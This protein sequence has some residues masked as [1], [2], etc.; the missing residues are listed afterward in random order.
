MR[1]RQWIGRLAVV[2]L[3]V[4]FCASPAWAQWQ[5]SSREN[6]WS[7]RF[8]F[9]A[10]GRALWVEAPDGQED[11]PQDLYLR[12]LRFMLGGQITEQLSFFVETDS[13]NLGKAGPD[14]SKSESDLFIQD[15]FV[16][17]A[18]HDAWRVDGGLLLPAMSYHHAQT[19]TGLV[20]T[21]YGPFS[22][23]ESGPLDERVGRDY[24]IQARGYLLGGA[25]ETRFGVYQ[26]RRGIDSTAPFRY[27]ARVAWQPFDKHTGIFYPGP[28]FGAK[29]YLSLGASYD[30]QDDYSAWSV[31]AFYDWPSWRTGDAVTLLAETV[32]LDGEEF[33]P[34]LAEQQ[35]SLFEATYYFGQVKLGPF[36]QWALRD[37]DA[38]I[39]ADQE[40]LQAGVTW[41]VKGHRFNLRLAGE[42]M[43]IDGLEA[44]E[45]LIAQI[46][47]F[48]Y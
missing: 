20:S 41:W 28:A 5:V 2:A 10:K 3:V 1:S 39:A 14:G 21:D 11:G 37:F 48:T 35:N 8:G 16:T 40:C 15:F 24:G 9:L 42:R 47:V 12:N 23:V 38:G 30:M 34:E 29:R 32:H 43:E 18:F 33:A 27:T 4:A 45:R 44:E 36:V 46:N 6:D 7:L 17:Y 25:I 19:K 22:F 13:P 26:G 31:G